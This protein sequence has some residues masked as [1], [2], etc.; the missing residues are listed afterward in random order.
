MADGKNFIL[1]VTLPND[2]AKKILLGAKDAQEQKVRGRRK[3]RGGKGKEGERGKG[4]MK[5]NLISYFLFFILF[6]ILF[7]FFFLNKIGLVP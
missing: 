1:M 2:P 4:E 6:F 7:L 5:G 3:E